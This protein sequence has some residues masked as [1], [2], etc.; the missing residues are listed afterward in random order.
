[1]TMKKTTINTILLA[2]IGVI[3]VFIIAGTAIALITE[4]AVP[5]EGLRR[6]DPTPASVNTRQN[7]VFN[8]IGQIRVFTKE[9]SDTSKSVIVL[10][11][12][13][14]YKGTDQSFYEELDRK[15]LSI[16]ALITHY[17]Q[18][19]TREELLSLGESS[20]KGE[21]KNLINA[22][23]VLGSISEIYFNDYLFLD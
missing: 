1:M 22:T 8:N 23:L 7:T 3:L 17:F 4:H 9:A 16:K 14:E 5:G 20:I 21:L 18:S 15:H 13:F 2:L 19:H 12:W 10:V 11:P 6:E